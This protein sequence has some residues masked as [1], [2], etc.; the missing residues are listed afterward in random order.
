MKCLVKM[1]HRR[2]FP[3]AASRKRAAPF[4]LH[5][6]LLTLSLSRNRL[7]V[8]ATHAPLCRWGCSS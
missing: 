7:N 2:Q 5:S 1:T 6:T 4:T 8:C 3:S